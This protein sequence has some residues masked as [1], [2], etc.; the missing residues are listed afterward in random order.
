MSPVALATSLLKLNTSEWAAV[1]SHF[2]T[3]PR[4]L[5]VQQG[6]ER[7]KEGTAGYSDEFT[8]DVPLIRRRCAQEREMDAISKPYRLYPQLAVA[9]LV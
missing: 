8:I 5:S 7:K 6:K 1:Y 3:V 9:L 4:T 2:D